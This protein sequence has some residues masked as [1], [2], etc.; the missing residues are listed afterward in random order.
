MESA[1]RSRVVDAT[2]AA[3]AQLLER[4]TG[5]EVALVDPQDLGGSGRTL[6]M[7]VRVGHNNFT[8]PRTVVV[9]QL[10]AADATEVDLGEAFAREAAAYKFATALPVESRPGPTLLA[11]DPAAGILVLSDLGLGETMTELLTRTPA[12]RAGTVLSA[13]GQALGRMH[14]GTVGREGDLS[15]LARREH[16]DARHDPV[17][18]EAARAAERVPTRLAEHGVTAAVPDAALRRG[19]GMFTGGQC[20]AFSPSDVG[21]DNALV[22]GGAVRFLDYEWAGFRDAG[23]DIAYALLT[24]PRWVAGGIDDGLNSALIEAW[25]SEVARIWPRLDDDRTLARH[26]T[27]AAL[28]WL[29]LA[30]YWCLPDGPDAHDAGFDAGHLHALTDWSGRQLADRWHALAEAEPEFADFA[31][32]AAAVVAAL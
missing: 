23:L 22:V 12:R 31:R 30:T 18:C 26:I 20:R 8:L 25:R 2:L 4:R 6:V 1:G 14:A 19:L 24:Y 10:L 32:G 16:T 29:T 7:R 3:V 28:V 11:S 17:G 5:M 13:W 27:T 9:K 15:A 21:P